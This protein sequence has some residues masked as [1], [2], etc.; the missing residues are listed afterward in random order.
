MRNLFFGFAVFVSILLFASC[1]TRS[2]KLLAENGSASLALT[3]SLKIKMDFEFKT[4][5]G[6]TENLSG[7]LFAVLGARYRLELSTTFGISVASLLWNSGNWAVAFPTEKFYYQGSGNRIDLDGNFPP[8]DIHEL[9]SLFWGDVSERLKDTIAVTVDS[10]LSQVTVSGRDDQKQIQKVTRDFKGRILSVE[11]LGL[12]GDERIHFQEWKA[13]ETLWFPSKVELYQE[14]E[15]F[16]TLKIKNVVKNAS[17]GAGIWKLP[18]PESY[19]R[20]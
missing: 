20:R 14:G 12:R 16:L 2:E 17:W 9:A 7:M 8:V 13:F 10:S 15:N 19:E 4:P 6:K 11:T 3:D 1:A 5:E 18:I